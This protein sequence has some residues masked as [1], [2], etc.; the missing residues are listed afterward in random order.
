MLSCWLG[1]CYCILGRFEDAER[2]RRWVESQ[3]NTE[4][5]LPEQVCSHMNNGDFY[6]E[7]KG[8]GLYTN[9]AKPEMLSDFLYIMDISLTNW[10]SR[11]I[12]NQFL[13]A[14]KYGF[15]GIY[16]DQYGFSK[17]SISKAGGKEEIRHLNEDFQS[18]I[19]R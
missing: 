10:W 4:G 14:I 15:D 12:Q 8:W 3:A 17:S 6:D 9:E 11:H 18:L 13:K 16:M 2:I 5:Y 19:D 7:H 1:W